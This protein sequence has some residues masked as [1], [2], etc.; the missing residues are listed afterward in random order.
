MLV[1]DPTYID[2][3]LR[4]LIK[5]FKNIAV[6]LVNFVAQRFERIL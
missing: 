2:C 5:Q 3:G 1:L 6:D 4:P